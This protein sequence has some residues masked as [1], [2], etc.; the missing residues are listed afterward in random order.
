MRLPIVTPVA[1]LGSV[2]PQMLAG[3]VDVGAFDRPLEVAPMAFDG[4]GVVDATGILPGGMIDGSVVVAEPQI[5][6]GAMAVGGDR[7]VADHVFE[8]DR[9]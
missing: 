5:A 4:V 7:G 2:F 1:E 8:D 3:D 6:V 9:F